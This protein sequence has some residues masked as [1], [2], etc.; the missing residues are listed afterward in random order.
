[1]SRLEELD[2]VCRRKGLRLGLEVE[3]VGDRSRV[4]RLV[5]K[6]GGDEVAAGLLDG[7]TTGATIDYVAARLI[8]E[9]EERGTA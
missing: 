2:R 1:M 6:R 4:S 5:V 3:R 8:D 9:L 7:R